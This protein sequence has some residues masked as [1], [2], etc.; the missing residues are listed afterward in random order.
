MHRAE[1]I[2]E[3]VKTTLMGLEATGANVERGHVYPFDEWPGL[4]IEMGEDLPRGETKSYAYQDR[5][6]EVEV[7][8]RLKASSNLETEANKIKAEVYNALM[9]DQTLSLSFV[10]FIEWAGDGKPEKSGEGEK[11]AISQVMNYVINYRHSYVSA[12]A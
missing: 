12:E 2:L 10:S 6:L 8:G 11:K 1:L 5:A 9:S 4:S 7:R 3:A